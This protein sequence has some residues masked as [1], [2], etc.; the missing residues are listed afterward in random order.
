M[1]TAATSSW[2]S[3]PAARAASS[4]PRTLTAPKGARRPP[5]AGRRRRRS[6]ANR[7][8]GPVLGPVRNGAAPILRRRRRLRRD[9][10]DATPTARPSARDPVLHYTREVACH[11]PGHAEGEFAPKPLFVSS[12]PAIQVGRLCRTA[13][14]VTLD[15]RVDARAAAR[16]ARI[17]AFAEGIQ[18]RLASG[19]QPLA[20]VARVRSD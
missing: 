4:T 10:H 15:L 8:S 13:T 1:T 19:P 16:G 7:R 3:A 9:R 20:P 14:T 6:S 18:P 11:P 2:L 12:G 5:A 17:G